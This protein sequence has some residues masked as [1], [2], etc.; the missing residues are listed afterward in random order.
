MAATVQDTTC[1]GCGAPAE[2]SAKTCEW[3]GRPVIITTFS[4]IRDWTGP[5]VSKYARAYENA[6][7]D[8][9][10]PEVKLALAICL[11]KLGQHERALHQISEAINYNVDHAEAY[12]YSAIARL[13]GKR[14]A[15]GNLAVLRNALADLESAKALEQRGAFFYLSG[16]IR[17]DYFERKR[18]RQLPT[19][20]DEF[21]A[22]AAYGVSQEDMRFL[23][24]IAN[25][26]G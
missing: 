8:T 6:L 7:A 2:L 12:F 25:V 14:P 5:E 13:G 11:L 9:M 4:T 23:H 1:P 19:S 17:S 21:A 16:L 10:S 20:A 3:C 22:A 15:L 26:S 18:I 24:E